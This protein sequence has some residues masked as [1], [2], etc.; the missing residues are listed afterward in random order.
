MSRN[1]GKDE[2][3]DGGVE[4][5]D[6]D[7]LA[8]DDLPEWATEEA[9]VPSTDPVPEPSE[10]SPDASGAAD[11]DAADADVTDADAAD[12]EPADAA[13]AV[14]FANVETGASASVSLGDDAVGWSRSA[15]DIG[16]TAGTSVDPDLDDV[17][18]STLLDAADDDEFP[19]PGADAGPDTPTPTTERA[20]TTDPAAMDASTGPSSQAS[21]V[22]SV[23]PD[24]PAVA[25]GLGAVLLLIVGGLSLLLASVLAPATAAGIVIV[26][27]LVVGGLALAGDLLD[28]PV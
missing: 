24:D 3:T 9:S 26:S 10:A 19:R 22:A 18:P 23:L 17:D 8:D 21:L 25:F 2:R 4:A 11:V 6:F 13:T 27:G 28:D 15:A 5:V 14:N 12:D 20:A 1:D 7:D 16:D